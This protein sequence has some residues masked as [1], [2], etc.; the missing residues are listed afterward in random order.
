MSKWRS[1]AEKDMVGTL[2]CEH[3]GYK[4]MSREEGGE[5]KST[6]NGPEDSSRSGEVVSS[7][8]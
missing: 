6:G 8:T 5:A 7:D 2:R 1:R 4:A 3:N